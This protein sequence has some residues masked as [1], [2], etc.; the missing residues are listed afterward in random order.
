MKATKRLSLTLA[1]I[2]VA[3]AFAAPAAFAK[4][5]GNCQCM[6]GSAAAEYCQ[7]DPGHGRGDHGRGDDR[8]RGGHDD[9]GHSGHDARQGRK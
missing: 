6:P 2:A 8:G 9:H 4:K 7:H 5:G 1:V 3:I